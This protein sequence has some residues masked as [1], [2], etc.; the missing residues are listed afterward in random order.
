MWDR[1]RV[2]PTSPKLGAILEEVVFPVLLHPKQ[3]SQQGCKLVPVSICTP[4][5]LYYTSQVMWDFQLRH[6]YVMRFHNLLIAFSYYNS[7]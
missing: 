3:G 4:C 6:Q 5:S 1:G 2:E 7:V